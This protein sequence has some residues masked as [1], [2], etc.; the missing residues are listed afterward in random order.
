MSLRV[1]AGALKIQMDVKFITTIQYWSLYY[2][3]DSL[4]VQDRPE[5]CHLLASFAIFDF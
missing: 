1:A 5:S 4:N 3:L 2:R